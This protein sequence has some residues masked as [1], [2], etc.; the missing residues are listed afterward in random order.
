M[1]H[2]R[3]SIIF[4][5]KTGLCTVSVIKASLPCVRVRMGRYIYG[6]IVSIIDNGCVQNLDETAF[7]TALIPLGKGMN[8]TILSP[9]MT[10]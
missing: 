3:R 7:H 8:P 10:K 5:S 2:D 4:Y 1:Q 6:V 9:A